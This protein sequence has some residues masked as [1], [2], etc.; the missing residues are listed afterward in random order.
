MNYKTLS[1]Y[2]AY[3]RNILHIYTTNQP[4]FMSSDLGNGKALPEFMKPEAF[5]KKIKK[6]IVK[7]GDK[8]AQI[9]SSGKSD[10]N[11]IYGKLLFTDII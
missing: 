1:S 7:P 2:E 4:Y 10:K 9:T 8:I 11:N 3:N 6:K 5:P